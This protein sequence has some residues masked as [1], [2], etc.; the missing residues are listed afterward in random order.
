MDWNISDDGKY[1][2]VY[3]NGTM[4][5]WTLNPIRSFYWIFIVEVVS[6]VVM[7]VKMILMVH[8]C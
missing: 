6:V 5:Q 4:Y 2:Y 7:I 1:I 3:T 8:K